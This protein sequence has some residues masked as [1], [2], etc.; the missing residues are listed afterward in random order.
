MWQTV[1]VFADLNSFPD[2]E[3]VTAGTINIPQCQPCSCH[4]R[5]ILFSMPSLLMMWFK[6]SPVSGPFYNSVAQLNYIFI[7]LHANFNL[8]LITERPVVLIVALGLFTVTWLNDGNE[9]NRLS[10]VIWWILF[11]LLFMSTRY[12]LL[13]ANALALKQAVIIKITH[14]QEHG[15]HSKMKHNT[16]VSPH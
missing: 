14:S 1:Y 8:T 10:P 11:T 7:G 4:P 12:V 16:F 3:P 13:H 6:Y 5:K 15:D 2:S 9:K